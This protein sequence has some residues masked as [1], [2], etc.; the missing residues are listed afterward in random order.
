[1]AEEQGRSFNGS[2][3]TRHAYLDGLAAESDYVRAATVSEEPVHSVCGDR[4]EA[5]GYL[6]SKNWQPHG[7]RVT[8]VTLPF[9][10]A[11]TYSAGT[12]LERDRTFE[13]DANAT[14]A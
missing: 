14:R 11:R 7:S 4:F 13:F 5:V 6:P 10:R 9:W 1:M 3:N 12:K 2:G 8:V